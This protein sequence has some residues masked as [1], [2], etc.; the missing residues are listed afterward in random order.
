MCVWSAM[1]Y[2]T[3]LALSDLSD[4]LLSTEHFEY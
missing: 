4:E 2:Y 1:M 3:I